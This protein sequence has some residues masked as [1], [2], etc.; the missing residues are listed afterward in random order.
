[1]VRICTAKFTSEHTLMCGT[2]IN[3]IVMEG[4]TCREWRTPFDCQASQIAALLSH[5]R[6]PQAGAV[7]QAATGGE[8]FL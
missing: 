2:G 1:M 3:P 5:S 7:Q 8:L 4:R 6:A